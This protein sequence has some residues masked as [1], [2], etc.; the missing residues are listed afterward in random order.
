[1]PRPPKEALMDNELLTGEMIARMLE[2]QER[3]FEVVDLLT[4]QVLEMKA[5]VDG[6]C[7]QMG[8]VPM[9]HLELVE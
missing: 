7:A 5:V 8:M 1:M 2:R 6:L 9:R 3:M 4:E